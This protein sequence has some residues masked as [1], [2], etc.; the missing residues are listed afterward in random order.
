MT[1]R[2]DMVADGRHILFFLSNNILLLYAYFI[3]FS[4][5]RF[6]LFCLFFVYLVRFSVYLPNRD[7]GLEYIGSA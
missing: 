7:S 2:T 3:L 4:S 6:S 1:H 5:V